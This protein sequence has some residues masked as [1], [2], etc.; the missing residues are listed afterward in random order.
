[1]FG[2]GQ[3]CFL[4]PYVKVLRC[5]FQTVLVWWGP[6]NRGRVLTSLEGPDSIAWPLLESPTKGLWVPCSGL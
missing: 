2:G 6:G 1:V 5:V 4:R 3:G